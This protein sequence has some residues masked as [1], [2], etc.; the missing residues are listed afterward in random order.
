MQC[1][2][3]VPE[4]LR[5]HGKW[6]QKKS[7]AVPLTASLARLG[8]NKAYCLALYQ[9]QGEE[10]YP[11]LFSDLLVC[12]VAWMC[13]NNMQEHMHICIHLVYSYC[14]RI[15][16]NKKGWELVRSYIAQGQG[17]LQVCNLMYYKY[18]KYLETV[19]TQWK[20]F[21]EHLFLA[22]MCASN[23]GGRKLDSRLEICLNFN[24]NPAS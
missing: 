19:N 24:P 1:A 7:K 3:I 20:V 2:Y 6:W 11:T 13:H 21:S 12:T 16:L 14:K 17:K 8:A 18:L 4:I 9:E 5:S 10:R 15:L 22:R 23:T